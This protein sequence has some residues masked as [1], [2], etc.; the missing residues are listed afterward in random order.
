MYTY[1]HPA[2][3]NKL[4]T[5]HLLT[6]EECSKV[7]RKGRSDW[8]DH[9]DLLLSTKPAKVVQEACQVLEKHGYPAREELKSEL[10]YSSTL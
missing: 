9:L 6:A 8:E 2:A 7:A 5:R 10:C 1:S 4:L 3:L